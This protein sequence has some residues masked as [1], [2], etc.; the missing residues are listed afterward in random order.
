MLYDQYFSRVNKSNISYS[1]K[2][3]WIKKVHYYKIR[4][5]I[6]SNSDQDM[7]RRTSGDSSSNDP[8]DDKLSL[9]KCHSTKSWYYIGIVMVNA[10]NNNNNGKID[11]K[12]WTL[13]Q[14]MTLIKIL[15]INSTLQLYKVWI[16][17]NMWEHFYWR[18]HSHCSSNRKCKS[19]VPNLA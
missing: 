19:S 6:M 17:D 8:K 10:G 12:R 4:I 14:I 9:S 11:L 18:G 5:I 13:F 16:T 7:T 3:G 1:K 2:V 15:N